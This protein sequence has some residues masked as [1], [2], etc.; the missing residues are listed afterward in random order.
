LDKRSPVLGTLRDLAGG[1]RTQCHYRHADRQQA[2]GVLGA[3][4]ATAPKC[5]PSCVLAFLVHRVFERFKDTRWRNVICAGLVPVTIGLVAASALIVAESAAHS[6]PARAT[7]VAT[8]AFVYWTTI[9]PLVPLG[10]AEYEAGGDAVDLE[11]GRF[12]P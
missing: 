3:L 11:G 12:V 6:W 10:V 4:I 5:V 8:A 2:A 1:A 7:T 9:T